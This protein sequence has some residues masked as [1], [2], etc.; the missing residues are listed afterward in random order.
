MYDVTV[1]LIQNQKQQKHHAVT[2]CTT[3]R[4]YV[5][6]KIMLIRVSP[7]NEGFGTKESACGACHEG[8]RAGDREGPKP[9]C[10]SQVVRLGLRLRLGLALL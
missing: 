4:T 10:G 8:H 6:V 2:G 3:N 9:L 7:G 1:L 5:H